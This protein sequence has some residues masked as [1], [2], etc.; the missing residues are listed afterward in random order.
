MASHTIGIIVNGATGRIGST[1]HLANALIPIIAE[2]GLAV[3]GD[4]LVP[5]L[6]LM[7]RDAG[8]L[9][10][11]ARTHKLADWSTDLD[12]ALADPAYTIFFDA[13]ATQGRIAVLEKALAAGKHV[14]CEKP[15]APS[16]AQGLALLRAAQR[17]GVKH[18]V[19]EDKI[20]LPGLQKLA[21]LT[22][23]GELGRVVGFRLEFGWW[24]FD[25]SEQPCQRPSW[26]YRAGGGGIILDMYPHWRYVIETIV[27][28]IV[29]VASSAWIA[30]PARIDERGG[31]YDV[32]VEDSAATCRRNASQ[33]TR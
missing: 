17:R 29:R 7:G 14:Y 2:G 22:R 21:A 33:P 15:V 9:A 12:A 4:R 31:R 30:T 16:A 10:A 20:H 3:G 27:G 13:A 32:A 5:R 25:G 11:A 8:R 6:L 18:G 28:R 23:G 24:V 1:Q 26:N 19:V